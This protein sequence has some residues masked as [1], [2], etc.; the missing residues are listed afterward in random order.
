MNDS[1]F[2]L[3]IIVTV[4]GLLWM[5][6]VLI[7]ISRIGLFSALSLAKTPEN[8]VSTMPACVERMKKAHSNAI[9]NLII[10]APLALIANSLEISFVLAAQVYLVSRICH[11]LAYSIGTSPLS[12][13]SIFGFLRTVSFFGGFFAQAYLALAIFGLV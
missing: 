2:W 7:I 10:F 11:Y 12:D 5:P 3:A 4:T 9:E 8:R 13:V 1:I 6:Y